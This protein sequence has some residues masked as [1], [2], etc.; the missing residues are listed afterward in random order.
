[1]SVW[2]IEVFSDVSVNIAVVI[3]KSSMS[4]GGSKALM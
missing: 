1:M 4:Y 3:L 2:N